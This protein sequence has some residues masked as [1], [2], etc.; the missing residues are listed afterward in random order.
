MQTC[1][2]WVFFWSYLTWLDDSYHCLILWLAILSFTYKLLYRYTQIYTHQI[3]LSWPLEPE[4][5][6]RERGLGLWANG[7]CSPYVL[8]LS[9][10]NFHFVVCSFMSF[11]NMYLTRIITKCEFIDSIRQLENEPTCLWNYLFVFGGNISSV[12]FTWQFST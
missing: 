11:A 6:R 4:Q 8:L 9:K 2:F 3:S 7:L 10:W 5:V 1:A 12:S